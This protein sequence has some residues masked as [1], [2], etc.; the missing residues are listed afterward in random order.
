MMDLYLYV[1]H[2]GRKRDYLVGRMMCPVVPRKGEKIHLRMVFTGNWCLNPN[3]P[4]RF[5]IAS[6]QVEEVIYDGHNTQSIEPDM[7]VAPHTE[8]STT[9]IAQLYVHPFDED[10][11]TYVSRIMNPQEE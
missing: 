10:T 4:V 8:S 2:E 5:D 11:L 9:H 7:K 1:R 3:N 6:F